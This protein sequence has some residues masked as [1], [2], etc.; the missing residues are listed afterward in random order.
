MKRSFE[1]IALVARGE[2]AV[3][4]IRAIRE[5]NHEQHLSLVAVAL[6]T[7]PDRQAVFVREADDAICIGPQ[8][9]RVTMSRQSIEV[10]VEQL[11]Q[12]NGGWTH[13]V[14]VQ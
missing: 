2:A 7:E 12:L 6:C 13:R 4:L 5:L 8:Q 1:K 3:R 9:Y 14:P 11:G 10:H